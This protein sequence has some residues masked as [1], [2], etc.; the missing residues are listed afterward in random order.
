M[1]SYY[2]VEILSP[3]LP[4]VV[5]AG[6]RCAVG[7]QVL[8]HNVVFKIGVVISEG[9]YQAWPIVDK[10]ELREL[11]TILRA[12]VE[13]AE[14]ELLREAVE[15]YCVRSSRPTDQLRGRI[16]SNSGRDEID[17]VQD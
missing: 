14:S 10:L 9:R 3:A 7:D 4:L 12:P 2:V 16:L 6:P 17:L 13:Y 1:K 11:A 15:E 5:L 8:A